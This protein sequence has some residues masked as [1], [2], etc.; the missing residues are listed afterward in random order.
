MPSSMR[1]DSAQ[2]CGFQRLR[3]ARADQLEEGLGLGLDIW[4]GGLKETRAKTEHFRQ[5][6]N[7]EL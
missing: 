6:F 5:R 3:H 4:E 1:I 7:R 2:L